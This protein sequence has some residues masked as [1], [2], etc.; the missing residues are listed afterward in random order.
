MPFCQIDIRSDWEIKM[1]ILLFLLF[2][3]VLSA[4]NAADE[5][6][7]V[8]NPGS[9]NSVQVNQFYVISRPQPGYVSETIIQNPQSRT[10]SAV[11]QNDDELFVKE[12]DFDEN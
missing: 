5:E 8:G 12:E 4:A 7:V 10:D 3:L 11:F 9:R 2:F 6:V 1:K